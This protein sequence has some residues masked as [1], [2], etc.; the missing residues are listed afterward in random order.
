MVCLSSV[1]KGEA[2]RAGLGVQRGLSVSNGKI[3]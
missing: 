1:Q 3:I 2:L